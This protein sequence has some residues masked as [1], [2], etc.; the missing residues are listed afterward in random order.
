M[1]LF[2][3]NHRA[4]LILV[5]LHIQVPL[6]HFNKSQRRDVLLGFTPDEHQ[7]RRLDRDARNR[8]IGH[9]HVYQFGKLH[10]VKCKKVAS[11]KPDQ[12]MPIIVGAINKARNK[13]L[14]REG[15]S[16]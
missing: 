2:V 13:S 14:A 1:V 9:F 7:L 8:A 16:H 6:L 12:N 11:S 5:Q 15:T 3:H 10:G 4:V